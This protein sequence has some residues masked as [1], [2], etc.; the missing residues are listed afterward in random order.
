MNRYSVRTLVEAM[1]GDLIAG[2]DDLMVESGV[3]TDT[4]TLRSGALY[5]ALRGDNFDGH[6]FLEEAV[7][8]GAAGLIV[9]SSTAEIYEAG[10]VPVIKVEDTPIALQKLAKWY[11]EQLDVIVIGITGSNGKTSTKD[12]CASVV[13][14]RYA[15]HATRGNL[16]NHI[17]LPLTLLEADDTDEVLVLEMGMNHPGEIAPLCEIAKPQIG[18]ITNVGHAHIE[19]LGSKEAIAEEKGALGRALPEVGTLLITAGCEFAEYFAS[20]SPARA[21]AVGNGRGVIRAESLCSSEGGSSFDLVIDGES[22][23]QVQLKVAGRHMVN[24]ALLA[25]GA[26]WAL[27]LSPDEIALGLQGARLTGG[28]LRCFEKKGITIYD[29]TYNANPDSVRA[30]IGVVADLPALNG[31]SRTVVLGMM[32]EL[33]RFSEDMHLQVGKHAAKQQLQVVS[34]GVEAAR[35]AEGARREG[36]SVVE[37]FDRYEDAAQ[38]LKETL[39]AGD[40]VLFKGSRQAAV[41]R[42]MNQVFPQT[43]N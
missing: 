29:D 6:Q 23:S 18:I 8:K 4:R 3:S 17:G 33:G 35:I 39:R 28:R 11:R 2:R 12:F 10:E 22:N 24:N 40:T 36:G 7:S 34:V 13:G 20:R 41:E 1:G 26:G 43:T 42:V 27:G 5:F 21:V 31:S 19:F 37:H 25:A 30:A 14:Q 15:V 9:S 32:G 38:W 16:N